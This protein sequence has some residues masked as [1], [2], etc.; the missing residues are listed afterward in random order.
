MTSENVKEYL[1]W[2]LG[3]GAVLAG[4]VF[5]AKGTGGGT[6]IE[7]KTIPAPDVSGQ[8]ASA[9]E[10]AKQNLQARATGVGY[11][12]TLMQGKQTA[13]FELESERLQAA[14]DIAIVKANN[15]TQALAIRS[16]GRIQSQA[17]TNAR[18]GQIIG[19]IAMI[20]MLACYKTTELAQQNR[21]TYLHGTVG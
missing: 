7:Y 12:A 6:G 18:I 1:P 11:I 3:G 21:S 19:G 9:F 15:E 17:N 10:L 4:V 2:I 20:A 8:Q 13:A 5:F 14:R 16:Q